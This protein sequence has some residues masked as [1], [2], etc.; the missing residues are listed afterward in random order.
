MLRVREQSSPCYCSVTL[1]SKLL[2]RLIPRDVTARAASRSSSV[3]GRSDRHC[4]ASHVGFITPTT[5]LHTH[6]QQ[7]K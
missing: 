2:R 3:T 5:L 6:T 1:E 7:T 4:T